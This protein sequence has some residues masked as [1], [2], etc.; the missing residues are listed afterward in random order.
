MNHDQFIGSYVNELRKELHDLKDQLIGTSF[1]DMYQL[2]KLQG[3]AAGLQGALDL[4]EAIYR[5]QDV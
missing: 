5:E 1:V 2:G 3:M 4:I